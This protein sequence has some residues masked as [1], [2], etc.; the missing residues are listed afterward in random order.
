MA[1]GAAATELVTQFSLEFIFGHS[2]SAGMHGACVTRR[3]DVGRA[4]HEVDLVRVLG[5]P[6]FVQK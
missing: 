5:E 3:G 2:R 6:H 1:I 4:P